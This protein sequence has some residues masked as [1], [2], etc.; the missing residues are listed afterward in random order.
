VDEHLKMKNKRVRAAMRAVPRDLFVPAALESEAYANR[1]LPIGHGQTISQPELVAA[2]TEL[3]D[4]KPDAKILEVGTGSGYQAAILSRLTPNVYTIEIIEALHSKA[5]ERL[6]QFGLGPERV[7]LGDGFFGLEKEAPFDGIIV[8]AAAAQ[9]PPPLIEQLRPGGRMI[10][11][12]GPAHEAQ[13]LLVLEKDEKGD[14]QKRTVYP[15]SF[16]PLTGGPGER[17][18]PLPVASD[19]T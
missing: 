15:V 3:L 18:E 16:V 9:I 14:V 5:R 6:Q 2:M 7:I 19:R 11:P 17:V 8:T 13:E 4:P 1:A 10:I 12:V